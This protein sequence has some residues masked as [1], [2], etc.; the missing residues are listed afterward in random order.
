ME[1]SP[2]PASET[3]PDTYDASVAQVNDELGNTAIA[4]YDYIAGE[5]NEISFAENDLIVRIEYVSDDWW[6]GQAP[7]GAV[8]LFPS[9]HVESR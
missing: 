5:E 6:Q 1:S 8:G 3:T 2:Q 9:N 7:N 4:I